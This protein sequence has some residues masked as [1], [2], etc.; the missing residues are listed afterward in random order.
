ML[1]ALNTP[2]QF[3]KYGFKTAMVGLILGMSANTFAAPPAWPDGDPSQIWD[4]APGVYKESDGTWYAIFHAQTSDSN[5]RLHGDFINDPDGIAMTKTPGGEYYWFRGTDASFSQPPAHGD[6]Y[7]FSVNRSGQTVHFVDPAARWVTP[8]TYGNMLSEAKSKIYMS[9]NYQWQSNNW[10]RPLQENLNIYQ[11]HPLRFTSRN[12]GTPLEQVTAELNNDG[13]NDHINNLGV[14]AIELLPVAEFSGDLSWGYNPSLFYA[15][16]TSYGGPDKLKE[17]VDTAHQNGIAVILDL[18]FNHIGN[19]DGTDG[20][21]EAIDASWYADGQTV[22]G[23]TFNFDNPVAKHYLIQNVLYLAKEFRIDG[24]RFDHT[25]SIH[26][27]HIADGSIIL[28]AGS[29]GGM[30]FLR[31]LYGKTKA[32]DNNIWFTAEELPDDWTVTADDMGST[33]EGTNHAPFDSQWTDIYHDN[34]KNVLMGIGNGELDQLVPVFNHFGDGWQ[35]ATVYTES[36]DEVGNWDGRIAKNAR[37]NRGQEMVMTSLA[38][39]ILARG[40]PMIFMG[41]EGAETQQFHI[42]WWNDRIPLDTYATDANQQKVLAWYKD[43][44]QIRSNDITS[45]AT[46]DSSTIYVHNIDGIAAFS[47]DNGKYIVVMNFKGSNWTNYDIGISGAYREIANTSWPQY[48]VNGGNEISRGGSESFY[49][50][51]VYVPAYG[52]VVLERDESATVDITMTCNNGT[53]VEGQ[54]VYAVGNIPELGNWDSNAAVSLD[55]TNYPTWS[56]TVSLPYNTAIEWKCIKRD[57]GA[58]EWQ[59]GN[60]NTYTTPYS[61]TGSTSGSF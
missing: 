5:V 2:K 16:E 19:W 34:F 14:T 56:A 58:V 43:L 50:T 60:N 12:S 6:E 9:D 22:W 3:T 27:S 24:F 52:V 13:V 21:L 7:S 11:L 20:V 40:T 18:E 45:F 17:L 29:G 47:R 51:D 42:D 35:D 28:E 8:S 61:G 38:G 59:S 10:T 55:G 33:V 15:I 41:Q 26:A 54:H 49:I 25:H 23:S 39:T 30:D 1:N 31:E 44:N 53:T 57:V 36:H 48:N 46:G 32:L 37:D 4:R